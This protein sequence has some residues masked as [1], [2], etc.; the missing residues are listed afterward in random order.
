VLCYHAVSEGWTVPLSVTPQRLRQQLSW[1]LDAGYSATTFRDAV[2]DPP[3][4]RTLAVT[5]DDAFRS[6]IQLAFPVLSDLG[7]PATVFAPTSFIGSEQP[8]A[9]PGI[10][11]W[12]T[13]ESA[14]ELVPMSWEELGQLAAHGWEIGSHTHTHPVLPELPPEAAREELLHSRVECESRLAGR[15]DSLAYPYG[16][17]DDDVI[18]AA[19]DAG[20]AVAGVVARK[21]Q[22]PE[23]LAWPRIGVYHGDDETRFRLK[24]SRLATWLRTSPLWNARQR[25]K[26]SGSAAPAGS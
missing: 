14:R 8:M 21:A 1:L 10:A 24:V 9:W 17:Y 2:L 22:K 5:F 18:T 15:C 13:G 16:A 20:Y 4:R 3:S 11:K 7:V 25:L 12:T 19:R 6:V 23:L 26:R